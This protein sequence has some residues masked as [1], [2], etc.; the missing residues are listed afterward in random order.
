MDSQRQ[1]VTSW[2]E[3]V[4][5]SIRPLSAGW[6]RKAGGAGRR[7]WVGWREGENK[8][9]ICLRKKSERAS[10]VSRCEGEPDDVR[11]AL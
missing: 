6:G 5:A 10:A 7:E 3:E 1:E 9:E 8:I 4:L 2:R 11:P